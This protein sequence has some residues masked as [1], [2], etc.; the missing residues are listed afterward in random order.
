ML[1]VEDVNKASDLFLSIVCLQIDIT[2]WRSPLL[3][4]SHSSRLGRPTDMV[5]SSSESRPGTSMF[6]WQRQQDALLLK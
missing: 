1:L 4:I 5:I 3:E 2:L 6:L